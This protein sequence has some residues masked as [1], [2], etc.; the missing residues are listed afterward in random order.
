M[1]VAL[2]A[3]IRWLVLPR[4]HEPVRAFPLF[5]VGLALAEGAAILGTFLSA[6]AT[7]L[8]VLGVVGMMQFVPFFAARLL[9]PRSAGF[10]PRG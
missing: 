1:A 9:A 4:F 10:R 6:Y 8:F 3:V 2:S 5:I 7:E